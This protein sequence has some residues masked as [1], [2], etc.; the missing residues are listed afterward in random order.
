MK[1][2]YCISGFG[3]DERVFGKLDFADNDVHFIQWKIPEK[4]ESLA[5]YAER[6]RQEIVHSNPIVIGLSFGGMMAVEIAKI[7]STEKIILMSSIATVD[8]MPFSMKLAGALHV[9]KFI[10]LRPSAILAPLEN[11]NLGVRTPEEK[12]L[13]S[14]YRKNINLVYSAW[15]IEQILQWKNRWYP[16]N[17]VHIHGSRD[18]IFP[19]KYIRADYVIQGSGHL[20]LMDKSDEV[21]KVLQ[22]II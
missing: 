4:K 9:N 2:L 14:E 17:A 5:H 6:M 10:P 1:H 15:A 13:V 16:E 21:S 12:K 3:A 8:E 11:Y 18:H 19:L 22:Q 7:I 20:C